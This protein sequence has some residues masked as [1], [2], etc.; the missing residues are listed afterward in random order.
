MKKQKPITLTAEMTV[1]E[2]ISTHP[3]VVWSAKNTQNIVWVLL[4]VFAFTFFVYRTLNYWSQQSGYNYI[5]AENAYYEMRSTTGERSTEATNRLNLLITEQPDLQAQYDGLLAQ[6]FVIKGDGVNA[7]PLIKR[8]LQRTAKETTPY[9]RQY[10]EATLLIA[11]DDLKGALASSIKLQQALIADPEFANSSLL[12]LNLLRMG[13]LQQKLELAE[14]EQ[15]TWNH[16]NDL[17][18][19]EGK[20]AHFEQVAQIYREG[21]IDFDRYISHRLSILN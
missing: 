20:V 16:W 9:H 12:P 3:L 7:Q 21:D 14:D 13:I 19:Q 10:A 4:V 2:R 18:K 1:S 17:A 8:A 11:Q 15:G 5:A 6:Y